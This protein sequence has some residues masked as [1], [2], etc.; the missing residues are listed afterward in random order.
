MIKVKEKLSEMSLAN[1]SFKAVYGV[2]VA[3]LFLV[4]V[5]LCLLF[6]LAGGVAVYE[7]TAFVMNIFR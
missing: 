3:S 5:I 1:V 7:I 4:A 2:N 6:V